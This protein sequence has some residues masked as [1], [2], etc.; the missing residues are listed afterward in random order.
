[1]RAELLLQRP[2]DLTEDLFL[3]LE[4]VIEGSVRQP[5]PLG[6]VGDPSVEESALLEHL[7]RRVDEPGARPDALAGAGSIRLLAVGHCAD[8]SLAA[9]AHDPSRCR[10][11]TPEGVPPPDVTTAVAAPTT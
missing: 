1:M 10:R 11:R 2:G 3:R 7:L 9:L 6:D 5:G 4:V 8:D